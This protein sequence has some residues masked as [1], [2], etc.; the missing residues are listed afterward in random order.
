[1]VSIIYAG[2]GMSEKYNDVTALVQSQYAAGTT[3]FQASNETYGPDPYGGV[4]KTLYIVYSMTSNDSGPGNVTLYSA[5]SNELGYP[6][7]LP[8]NG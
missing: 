3:E 7:I 5:S 1:M 6:A 8:G 2:Y 4:T